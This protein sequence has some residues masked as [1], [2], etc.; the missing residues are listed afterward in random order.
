M[1]LTFR[2]EC[3]IVCGKRKIAGKLRTK[4]LFVSGCIWYNMMYSFG[5]V[6]T[7]TDARGKEAS[8]HAISLPG[9]EVVY[10]EKDSDNSDANVALQFARF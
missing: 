1:I 9:E 7:D 8:R 5:F 2:E 3:D 10:A 6:K 4:N